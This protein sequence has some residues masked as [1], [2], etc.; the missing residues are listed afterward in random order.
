M[1]FSLRPP[2]L[3]WR[4]L[5]RL[6]LSWYFW[7]VPAAIVRMYGQYA[8]AFAEMFSFTF[9]LRSLFAPWKAITD[10]YPENN[11]NWELIAQAFVL[12]IV[13]RIIGFIFRIVA[14]CIGV[15]LQILCLV[16]FFAGLI[17]WIAYPVI[18]IIAVRFLLSAL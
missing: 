2:R 11:F 7:E 4:A 10:E 1:P 13:T 3:A 14:I 17:V 18:V 9:M 12:N 15:I 8:G 16:G 5:L 6:F